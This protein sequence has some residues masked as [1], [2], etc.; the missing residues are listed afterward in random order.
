MT[1]NTH[2]LSQA[3]NSKAGGYLTSSL[4]ALAERHPDRL[5]GCR[6]GQLSNEQL[7]HQVLKIATWLQRN[8][9][10]R[11]GVVLLAFSEDQPW[12]ETVAL[13]VTHAG[14][15]V[16]VL[17]KDISEHRFSGIT[18]NCDLACVFLD[19]GTAHLQKNIQ[20]CCITVWMNEG[21][22]T[23]EWNEAEFSELLGTK[24]AWGMPFP[25]QPDDAAFLVFDESDSVEGETWS[26]NRLR[27]LKP[28]PLRLIASEARLE[29]E[30]RR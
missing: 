25:G 12:A 16:S 14:G 6:G 23:G 9:V 15:V 26:H 19:A 13:A 29:L 27:N 30:I 4:V 3:L 1:L 21:F 22:S 17:P 28:D 5:S 10:E 24:A 8:G 20:T 18:E 11:G 2:S 7:W